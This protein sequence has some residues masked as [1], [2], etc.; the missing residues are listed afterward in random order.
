MCRQFRNF[1]IPRLLWAFSLLVLLLSTLID[2]PIATAQAADYPVPGGW[3]FSQTGGDSP[4]TDDGYTVVNDEM[5][6]FWT[7]FQDFGGVESVGYPV[8]R[9][10]VWDG[11]V[12]QAM[13]KVVFQWRPETDSVAFVNVFDD[14]HRRGFDQELVV[15]LI[16]AEERFE[17]SGLTFEQ[18]VR[19]RTQLLAEEPALLAT[20]QA[21]PNPLQFF[22]LPTSTIQTFSGLRSIRMQRAVLQIWT[23]DF[24]WAKAGQVTIANGGDVAK[25]LGMF[26][27]GAMYPAPA[28]VPPPPLTRASAGQWDTFMFQNQLTGQTEVGIELPAVWSDP[29]E[30][31]WLATGRTRMGLTCNSDG[32]LAGFVEWPGAWLL[33]WY[34]G[35]NEVEPPPIRYVLD[36]EEFV[37]WWEEDSVDRGK[38]LI[39]AEDLP[40]LLD[41]IRAGNTLGIEY[42]VRGDVNARARF[43]VPGLDW[44]LQQLPCQPSPLATTLS[45][46]KQSLVRVEV[47][48]GAGSGVVIGSESGR[49][50]ILT[51]WHVVQSYCDRPGDEC[52]GVSVVSG[53]QRHHGNL[54]SFSRLEDLAI[55]DVEGMFPVAELAPELPPLDS[56][57]ITI[58][59]P[60]GE[61]DFQ[62]NEG[63]IVRYTGCSF[64]SCLATNARAWSGFS[65]G[66]LINLEGEIV[67]VISEGWAGSFYSNAVS[68]DAI[69][70]LLEDAEQSEVERQ[71]ELDQ[72]WAEADSVGYDDL[73]RNIDEHVGKVVK[74][75][76]EIVQVI[77][78]GG[79]R[80]SLRI[81]VTRG[82]YSWTDT[83]YA[84][85]AG[86]RLLE[87]DVIDF[88]GTVQGLYAYSTIFGGRIT[89]PEIVILDSAAT[90]PLFD[91][92]LGI[93]G[94][95]EDFLNAMLKALEIEWYQ[96]D[97]VT[98]EDLETIADRV[99]GVNQILGR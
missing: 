14:L 35:R 46:A 13:Q 16:P 89:L 17:E 68:V 78:G 95:P 47:H 74:F 60:D 34:Q 43:E 25:Q 73:F 54:R 76:G 36:G 49:S 99:P 6:R 97:E 72:L 1:G 23:R 55:L 50:S 4:E 77:D 70:S 48:D 98:F 69:R 96:C 62:F 65:G 15:Q 2:S 12:T 18:I 83:I 52:I 63:R 88:V 42:V 22:G 11:F 38:I 5:A 24:P 92:D 29:D 44:A 33:T 30:S 94:Y 45:V 37:G 31:H 80:Y 10:F 84:R 21:A 57:V 51:A 81:N 56:E 91:E 32:D 87:D 58:G 90:L 85:Y 39:A 27:A 86:E 79:A 66:A 41:R 20:Y 9:R 3:F 64:V 61:H 75:R 71:V 67:G 53:G 19:Q 40:L 7:A 8:S 59:M 26:P 28:P 93:C 82:T